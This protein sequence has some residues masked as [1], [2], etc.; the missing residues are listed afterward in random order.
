MLTFREQL[1]LEMEVLS[2]RLRGMAMI[3]RGIVPNLVL[4]QRVVDK[5]SVAAQKFIADETGEAMIGFAL[6]AQADDEDGLPTI[7]VLETISPDET[8]IRQAHTFQQGDDLQDEIIWWLQ[9]NW[10]VAREQNKD[11]SGKPLDAKWDEP[12]RYLGD[13]HKQ[14][15]YMIAPSGGDL[16]T[17][18]SWLD[19]DE[20]EMEY[21]LVPIVTLGHPPTTID[22]DSEY[23][24]YITIPQADGTN[25]RVDWWYIHRYVRMFQPLRPVVVDAE[26]LPNL[27]GYPWHLVDDERAEEELFRLEADGLLANMILWEANDE[28]PLEICFLVARQGS[29][30]FLLI[31]TKW[32]YPTVAPKIRIAPFRSLRQG[33]DFYDLFSEAWDEAELI[34]DPPDWEWT[35]DTYLVEYVHAIEDHLGIV[36]QPVVPATSIPVTVESDNETENVNEESETVTDTEIVE[37]IPVEVDETEIPSSS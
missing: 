16:M 23:R 33:E 14:P 24:N 37:E 2:K 25:L 31:S 26:S 12:L 28:L 9:E 4:S 8:A 15:G 21:L 10:R 20:N 34:K 3:A 27:A 29:D 36:R 35:K 5:I 17:A 32:N 22:E 7:Y 18:L 30:K 19:D 13:W 11:S 6:P 1:Q